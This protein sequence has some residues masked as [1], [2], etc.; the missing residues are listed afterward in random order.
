MA[1]QVSNR[2]E[3]ILMSVVVPHSDLILLKAV[4]TDEL[5]GV[6]APHHCTHLTIGLLFRDLITSLS[7]PNSDDPVFRSTSRSEKVWITLGPCKSLYSCSMLV[8]IV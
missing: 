6:S 5:I 3:N 1:A 7:V 4:T 8:L 2:L